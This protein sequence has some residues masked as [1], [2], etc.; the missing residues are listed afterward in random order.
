[1][2]YFFKFLYVK[3]QH[4]IFFCNIKTSKK[5]ILI[6]DIDNTIADTW[7]T[8]NK[9]YKSE[10]DRVISIKPLIGTINY[11]KSKYSTDKYQWI[12]LS[13]RNYNIQLTTIK[14]LKKNDLFANVFNVIFVQKPIEKIYLINKYVLQSFVYFDDLS[15]NHENG[16]VKFYVNEISSVNS[17]V[18]AKYYDYSHIINLNK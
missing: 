2:K 9:K 13:R 1:M 3:F 15:Y 7:P 17:N 10:Q 14:W 18:L 16:E 6:L 5:P 4:F 8:L 11:L 12:Y